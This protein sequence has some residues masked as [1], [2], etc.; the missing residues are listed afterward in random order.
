MLLRYL[1]SFL[2]SGYACALFAQQPVSYNYTT[3]DGLPSSEMY[4]LIQDRQGFIW[5]ATDRGVS[6]FDGYTFK[7]FTTNEGLIDNTVLSLAEDPLGRIWFHGISGRI[8]YYENG[9]I[10]KYKY[11]ELLTGSKGAMIRSFDCDRNGNLIIG[12]IGKGLIGISANGKKKDIRK[13][14][15]TGRI[16]TGCSINGKFFLLMLHPVNILPV[17]RRIMIVLDTKKKFS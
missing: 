3:S 8:C 4:D 14:R 7:N 10:I 9:K 16:F 11:N 15:E 5:I 17:S 1:F 6:R 2:I 13:S 12:T